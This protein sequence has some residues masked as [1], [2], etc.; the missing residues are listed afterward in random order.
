MKRIFLMILAAVLL[1]ALP[2]MLRGLSNYRMLIYSIILITMMILNWAPSVLAW[3]ERHL[4]SLL[5]RG[6]KEAQ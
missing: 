4:G 1:T 2:E 6:R 3:R 5:H